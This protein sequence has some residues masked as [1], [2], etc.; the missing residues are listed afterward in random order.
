MKFRITMKD[1]DGVYYAIN[2]AA[3][4]AINPDLNKNPSDYSL[5]D[6][7]TPLVE[8]KKEEFTEL[9]CKWFRW[10]EYLTVEVDTEAQTISVVEQ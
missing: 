9:L 5:H 4:D 8:E 1:P 3:R 6:W 10:Q 7:T 2:E